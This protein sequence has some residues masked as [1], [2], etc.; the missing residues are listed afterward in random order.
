MIERKDN[1]LGLKPDPDMAQADERIY[2]GGQPSLKVVMDFSHVLVTK[3]RRG[4]K[5]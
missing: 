3:Q 1:E 2:L 4:D 5:R